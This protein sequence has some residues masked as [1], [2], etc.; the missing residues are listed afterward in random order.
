M[1]RVYC[2]TKMARVGLKGEPGSSFW[3][4]IT[5][6]SAYRLCP[7]I[8]AQGCDSSPCGTTDSGTALAPKQ[9]VGGCID[10]ADADKGARVA[11]YFS[12]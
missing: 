3:Q 6:T 9:P 7:P 8:T 10:Q 2:M 4:F 11:R 1:Q 5:L 12:R